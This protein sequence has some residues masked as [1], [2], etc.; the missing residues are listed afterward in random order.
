MLDISVLKR[1]NFEPYEFHISRTAQMEGI[2]N[3]V[4]DVFILEN[5]QTTADKMQEVRDFLDCP[6]KMSSVYRC[7]QLN[8]F[9]E[10]KDTSQH[11]KGEAFDFTASKFGTP[12][13]I[14]HALK[15]SGIEF[16]QVLMEGTWIH[17]SYK[18]ES[19]NRNQFAYF[20]KGDD[21]KRKFVI[22]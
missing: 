11:L 18:A 1:P 12:K 7:L 9:I 19:K 10:S 14:F 8:R 15:E 21:G 6:M 4:Y 22:I 16:D 5:L 17:C 2:D 3:G 13:E 20:E